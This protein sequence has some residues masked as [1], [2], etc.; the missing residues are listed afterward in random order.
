MTKLN[1]PESDSGAVT[2]KPLCATRWTARTPAIHAVITDYTLLLEILEEIHLTTKDEYGLKAGGLLHSLEKFSTLFGLELSHLLFSASEQVSL[3]LQT[4]NIALHDALS[5]VD[6]AKN[7][8]KGLGVMKHLINFTR[9]W[10]P[11]LGSTVL[12]NLNYHDKDDVQFVMK[13]VAAIHM[14]L[15]HQF[16]IIVKSFLKLVICYMENYSNASYNFH[17]S[18]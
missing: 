12:V 10:F 8:S 13:I 15:L 7:F 1:S 6:A 11:L 4:K 16:L 2:L 18:N 14:S 5:A 3:T 9:S 17:Y